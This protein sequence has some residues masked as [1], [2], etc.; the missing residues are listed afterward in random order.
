MSLELPM[1][2]AALVVTGSAGR[3]REGVERGV[4]FGLKLNDHFHLAQEDRITT[5][6]KMVVRQHEPCALPLASSPEL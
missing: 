2:L 1:S 3:L 6:W 4:G 5:G